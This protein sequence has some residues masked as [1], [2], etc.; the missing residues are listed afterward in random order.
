MSRVNALIFCNL[1]IKKKVGREYVNV[2]DQ[3]IRSENRKN[4]EGGRKRK[5]FFPV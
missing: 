3:E 5:F 4:N 2:Q 1:F